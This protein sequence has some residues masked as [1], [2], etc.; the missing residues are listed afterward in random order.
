M[1]ELRSLPHSHDLRRRGG[2]IVPGGSVHTCSNETLLTEQELSEEKN[3]AF[4]PRYLL[5][6]PLLKKINEHSL[7]L[8][9]MLT[10]DNSLFSPSPSNVAICNSHYN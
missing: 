3:A 1:S 8:H 4:S 5:K 2:D 10:K 7:Y 9:C 6:S